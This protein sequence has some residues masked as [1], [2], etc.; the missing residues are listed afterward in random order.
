MVMQ[1]TQQEDESKG[2]T[3]PSKGKKKY[4]DIYPPVFFPSAII[5]IVFIVITM[6][7]GEPMEKVFGSVQSAIAKNTGWFF[8]LVVN[9][10]LFFMIYLA[11]SKYGRVRLG[12]ENARPAFTRT[13]WF[14]MLFSAGM[15][16][17][18]LFWS[19]AEPVFHFMN[20]ALG[21]AEAAALMAEQAMNFTFL[22]WGLHAWGIYALLGMALAFFAFNQKLPLAMRSVFYPIFGDRINGPIGNVIEIMAVIATVF[23]LATSLGFGVKQVNAGLNYLFDVDISPQIQALLILIITLMATLSVV[24]GLN[25]GVKRLSEL[26]INIGAILLVIV[27]IAGPTLFILDSFVQNIGGYVQNFFY[28]SF[29]TESYRQTN[30]QDQWTIFYWS[31]W[32]SWSP[33]VGMFIARI[34]VGRTIREFVSGVLI[35]PTLLTFLWLTAFGGTAISFEL[36][37]MAS[38]AG[39]VKKDVAISLYALLDHFPI[40]S[41]TNIV[42]IILVVSFFVTSSDS[43]SLVVD[44][45]TSGGKLE[46]P[47]YQRIFWA[48]SVG[49]VAAVLLF[50]GG[51]QALQ[52][53]TITTGLPFALILVVMSRSLFKGIRKEY[54]Q[55]LQ[56]H[57]EKE[58]ESYKDIVEELMKKNSKNKKHF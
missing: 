37:D 45:F 10:F 56:L 39:T 57:N 49:G 1:N 2:A 25:A 14:A 21:D 19:V 24:S 46:T 47:V 4:I 31:W 34:S 20:P 42:A 29:W 35:V 5:I 41:F 28:H 23:G 6:L 7:V 18:I 52:T 12:G 13:A 22:H 51:L 54:Y 36:N 15:G 55:V 32:I 58:K 48:F 53:A 26:N 44:I 30:W 50:G 27:I 3:T 43:G 38:M 11:F 9:F 40:A 16:I 8:V 33:F 17:G